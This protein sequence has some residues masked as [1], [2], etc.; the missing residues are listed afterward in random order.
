MHFI[1]QC[2]LRAD[3]TLANTNVLHWN[4][5]YPP[6]SVLHEN[7]TLLLIEAKRR[8]SHGALL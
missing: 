5:H 8:E 4:E 2:G 3:L 7:I 6:L 1:V